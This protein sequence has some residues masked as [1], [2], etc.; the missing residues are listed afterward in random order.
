MS[1]LI[2]PL[3]EYLSKINFEVTKYR[4]T[5]NKPVF[6]SS[7][8]VAFT[9][10]KYFDELRKFVQLNPPESTELIIAIS[11]D[12]KLQVLMAEYFNSISSVNTLPEQFEGLTLNLD[13][14]DHEN[15][16]LTDS[17]DYVSYASAEIYCKLLG[18]KEA[19][20]LKEARLVYPLYNPRTELKL[21]RDVIP[22][23]EGDTL[24]L[25]TYIPPKWKFSKPTS[26]SCPRLFTKL[27][28]HLIP[29]DKDRKYLLYWIRKSMVSRSMVYLVLCG[30]PGVGK[31]TLKRVLK[32][33][34]GDLNTVDGKKSTLTTQF[35]SQLSNGTLIWFDELRYNEAEENVM[36]EIPN[37]SISI[38]SKGVD[39]SRST[40]LYGSYV[41]SNNKPRDNYLS[42]D[43]RKFAPITLT[44]KRLEESMDPKEIEELLNK[45]DPTK[46]TYD[47]Q[48]ISQMA[49][50]ILKNCDSTEWPND[51]YRSEMF[52][53]LTHTSMTKWQRKLMSIISDMKVGGHEY[54]KGK[55]NKA[56]VEKF[57]I[58][59]Y[60]SI[61]CSA[62][63]LLFES[64]NKAEK[65]NLIFPEFSTVESFLTYYRDLSGN[66]V[67]K[68]TKIP[69]NVNGDFIIE[70]TS[71]D[72]SM[73]IPDG[74]FP[75]ENA[76]ELL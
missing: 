73:V 53:V 61:S 35:N 36:K 10:K 15:F 52:Y 1:N 6:V 8:G 69:G 41:I 27:V 25:N 19:D 5:A 59:G 40:L 45:L 11:L 66:K 65:R 12:M 29:N 37:D 51:E 23:Y 14:S 20:R 17:R 13:V 54:V 63:E 46:E 43:A 38:E 72:I 62:M 18:L 48:F 30:A 74:L 76:L 16:F 67:C 58:Y 71:S 60:G 32:A 4:P 24:I 70:K 39:A 22:G 26:D 34:H 7:L 21:Y 28:K 55:V 3:K 56:E 44:S 31:N 47:V 2:E 9:E 64:Y 75:E 50:W 33:L 57:K 49:N 42:M 68:V